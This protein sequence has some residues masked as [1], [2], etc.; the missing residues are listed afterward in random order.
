MKRF[1]HEHS[2]KTSR[3]LIVLLLFLVFFCAFVYGISNISSKTDENETET[4]HLA[5]SRGITHCYATEGHYP[6]N[7]EYLL[8]HYGITY[9]SE[10]YFVDYQV[11]GENIFPD[12]TII[13]K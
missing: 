10:K 7:L 13:E 9:D 2:K 8:T 12:V 1:Y 11:L 3:Q 6:E 4:L 5:I